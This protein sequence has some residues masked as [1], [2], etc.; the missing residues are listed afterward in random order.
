M[1]E[2]AKASVNGSGGNAV[3][4]WKSELLVELVKAIKFAHTDW[5]VNKIHKHILST[6][7]NDLQDEVRDNNVAQ[8]RDW[9][10]ST[11]VLLLCVCAHN[12]CVK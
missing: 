7:L 8:R 12:L 2:L 10:F 3:V 6:H 11:K 1:A 4:Y 5:G 9:G